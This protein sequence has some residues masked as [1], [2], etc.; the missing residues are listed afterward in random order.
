MGLDIAAHIAGTVLF[1]EGFLRDDTDGIGGIDQRNVAVAERFDQI[2]EHDLGNASEVLF[3][4]RTERNDLVDAV[5]ELGTEE[6][7]KC[8]FRA[9]FG[10]GLFLCAEA[11][12]IVVGRRAGVGRHDDDRIFKVDFL[13]VCVGQSAVIENLQKDVHDIGMRLLDFVKEHDGIRLA[14]DLLG[15][16]SCIVI[17]DIAGRRTDDAGNGVLF[18]IFGHVKADQG[19][20]GI[21]QLRGECLHKLGLTDT[22]GTCENERNGLF[23][24]GNADA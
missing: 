24:V 15:Q 12:G 21:E 13:A 8:L 23:L 20:G 4:K 19:I 9:V 17:A 6:G 22:G 11:C 2:S 3:A 16:L 18:H 5:D 14:A 10:D 7:Q 1:R